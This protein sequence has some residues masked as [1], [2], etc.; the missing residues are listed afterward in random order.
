[1][2]KRAYPHPSLAAARMER[3][4]LVLSAYQYKVEHTLGTENHY[5]DCLSRL[6][7]ATVESDGAKQEYVTVDTEQLLKW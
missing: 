2:K 5:A 6:P 7:S 3:W 1:V 4:V